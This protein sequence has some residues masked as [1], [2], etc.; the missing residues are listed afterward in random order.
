MT[1]DALR[2]LQDLQSQLLEPPTEFHSGGTEEADAGD[3]AATE[4]DEAAA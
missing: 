3:A 1:S 2:H 4:A